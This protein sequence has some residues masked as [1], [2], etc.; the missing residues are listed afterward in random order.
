M[1][2]N[3]ALTPASLA[4]AEMR[5]ILAKILWHFDLEL[6]PHQDDWMSN[7]RVFALWEKPALQIRLTPVQR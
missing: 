5:L 4:Y 7:Q 2:R 3:N 1:E 6:V